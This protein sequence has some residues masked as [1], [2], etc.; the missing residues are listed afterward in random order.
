MENVCM[1]NEDNDYIH[2]CS[3][4]AVLQSEEKVKHSV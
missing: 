3:I 2:T 1:E 4:V